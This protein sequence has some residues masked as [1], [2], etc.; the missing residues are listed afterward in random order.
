MSLKQLEKAIKN[1]PREIAINECWN[2]EKLAKKLK[3]CVAHFEKIKVELA[4]VKKAC[5]IVPRKK[6]EAKIK[7]IECHLPNHR[8][9]EYERLLKELLGEETK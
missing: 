3:E 2:N 8:G 9:I 5:V 7:D 4:S 6:L 1:F